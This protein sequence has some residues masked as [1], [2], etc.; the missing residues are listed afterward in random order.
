MAI[1]PHRPNPKCRGIR[2]SLRLGHVGNEELKIIAA[3]LL[4]RVHRFIA[5]REEQ[6]R[7]GSVSRMYA[8]ADA[9]GGVHSLSFVD[10]HRTT[11]LPADREVSQP[12]SS[13]LVQAKSKS[14]LVDVATQEV[15]LQMLKAPRS[16]G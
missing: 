8:D 9:F 13:V 4:C 11:T 7:V 14:V 15:N 10:F 12:P 1:G 16:M 2:A 3:G 5:M 6:I